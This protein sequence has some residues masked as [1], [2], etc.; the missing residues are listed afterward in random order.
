VGYAV[1]EPFI[2]Y[3]VPYVGD[4][5]RGG[6]LQSLAGQLAAIETRPTVALPTLDDFDDRFRPLSERAPRS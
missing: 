5:V 2:A 1:H 6:M 3:H 4:E